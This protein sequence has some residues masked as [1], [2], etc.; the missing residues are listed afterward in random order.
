MLAVSV[1]EN[2]RETTPLGIENG[3][4]HAHPFLCPGKQSRDCMQCAV[5]ALIGLAKA[6]PE[7]HN[8]FNPSTHSHS[9]V[10]CHSGLAT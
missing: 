4:Q 1:Q 7:Q 3:E 2:A 10:G 8:N 9:W 5:L 6:R